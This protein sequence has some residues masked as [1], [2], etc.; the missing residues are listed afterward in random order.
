MCSWNSQY[1]NY[2]QQ[3]EKFQAVLHMIEMMVHCMFSKRKQ[4]LWQQE[5][6]QDVGLFVLG[7]GSTPERVTHWPIG[8]ELKWE[9]WNLSSS[10][11]Q[12]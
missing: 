7:H 1:V 12:V 10:I 9:I 6:Q 5:V 3:R 8:Q 11:L 4:L 2:S